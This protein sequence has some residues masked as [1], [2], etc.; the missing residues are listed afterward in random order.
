[1]SST[2]APIRVASSHTEL[3]DSYRLVIFDGTGTHVYL[4]E[5]NG[6][7]LFPEIGIPK[8]TRVLAE[9]GECV[10]DRWNIGTTLLFSDS[11]SSHSAESSY[12]VLE[13][14][15]QCRQLSGLTKCDVRMASS[16][17]GNMEEVDFF[18]SCCGR[19]LRREGVSRSG[20]F[21]QLGWVYTLLERVQRVPGVDDIVSFSQLSGSDDTCLVRF[22][23]PSKPLWYKAVGQ[24]DPKE[25]AITA[26][27]SE[28]LPQYL[29]RILSFD[30]N[31]NA[32]LMES[33]GDTTLS[34]HLDFDTWVAIAR[35]LATM[36]IDSISH[37]PELLKRGAVDLR[38]DN[39]QELV[40][41]FFKF[42]GTLMQQQVKNPPPPLTIEEL[43]EI[44]ELLRTALSELAVI[45][46]PDAIGHVDFNPG[47]IIVDADRSV[48]IDW[49][50]AYVGSPLLSFEYLIAHFKKN[51]TV[52]PGQECSLRQAYA[53]QWLS[54][55]SGSAMCRAQDCATLIAVFASAVA[56]GDWRNLA[57]MRRLGFSGYLRSLARIM[58]REAHLFTE[59]RSVLA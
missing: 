31:L 6:C 34:E 36:Q 53:E 22:D 27:L 26:A 30:S 17:L 10:R 51:C 29:P 9:I 14:P 8:F 11:A 43:T 2:I 16:L 48:F 45:A 18:R 37:A 21:S 50:S 54:V 40:D 56:H 33:G 4:R 55:V 49:S 38:A 59:R 12:A 20:P 23:R 39:L 46:I 25:F 52:L 47:N 57:L 58:N 28:W 35:R 5:E 3:N 7:W 15:R 42:M 41:P 1:M 13:A 32:W 19:V 44:A 24:S